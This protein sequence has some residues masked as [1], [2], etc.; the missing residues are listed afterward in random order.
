MNLQKYDKGLQATHNKDYETEQFETHDYDDIF[1]TNL[2]NA[3]NDVNELNLLTGSK[4]ALL[5]SG[6]IQGRS[7]LLCFESGTNN[8]TASVSL[9]IFNL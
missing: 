7:Y 5:L 3:K 8:K 9:V 2:T 4:R 1:K 6:K